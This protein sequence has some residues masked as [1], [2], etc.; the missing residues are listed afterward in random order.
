MRVGLIFQ[1]PDDQLFSPTVFENVAFGPLHM[2]LPEIEVRERARG[3]SEK[4]A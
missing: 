2:G 1:D 4:R 3:R